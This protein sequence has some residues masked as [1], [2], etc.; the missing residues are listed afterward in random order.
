MTVSLNREEKIDGERLS[1][2]VTLKIFF[3]LLLFYGYENKIGAHMGNG[4]KPQN[5]PQKIAVIFK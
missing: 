3:F 4:K 5:I 1:K 2:G